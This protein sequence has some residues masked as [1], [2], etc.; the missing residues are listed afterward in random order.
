MCLPCPAN[1]TTSDVGSAS[2]AV[3]VVPVNRLHP[4]V[5]YVDVIFGVSFHQ[6][7]GSLANIQRNIG[8]DGDADA[9][10]QRALEIDIALKFNVTRGAVQ[11]TIIQ[12]GSSA[13]ARFSARRLLQT[14]E[15]P[16]LTVRCLTGLSCIRAAAIHVTV[17]ATEILRF[18]VVRDYDTTMAMI[19]RTRERSERILTELKADPVAFFATTSRGIGGTVLG[20]V[21]EDPVSSLVVE[22]Q[23]TPVWSV[24]NV[25]GDLNIALITIGGAF[26]I[27]AVIVACVFGRRVRAKRAIERIE[28]DIIET[29]KRAIAADA[30]SKTAGNKTSWASLFSHKKPDDANKAPEKKTAYVHAIQMHEQSQKTLAN[31]SRYRQTRNLSAI[32]TMWSA[33]NEG[34][35]IIGARKSHRQK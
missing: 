3:P 16:A 27:F 2:C 11:M 22:K 9:A 8:V 1:G 35:K 29:E 26:A 33:R 14:T 25:F 7:G 17:Q 32:Q 12:P 15:T 13:T 19:E 31:A 24:P 20:S 18:G 4:D 10:F 23:P 34:V 21:Y 6:A 30:S 5:Y 28:H